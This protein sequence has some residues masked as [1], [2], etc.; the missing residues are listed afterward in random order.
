MLITSVFTAKDPVKTYPPKLK[1][2]F[3]E[4]ALGMLGEMESRKLEVVLVDNGNNDGRKHRSAE[5]TN[6]EWYSQLWHK[7]SYP[8]VNKNW[9]ENTGK[10]TRTRPSS[11]V[12]RPMI[13]KALKR[14]LDGKDWRLKTFDHSRALNDYE[15]RNIILENL[16]EGYDVEGQGTV[17]PRI[18]ICPNLNF[19]QIYEFEIEDGYSWAITPG[20]PAIKDL[21]K[22]KLRNLSCEINSGIYFL[23]DGLELVYIGVSNDINRRIKEHN[24]TRAQKEQP[25]NF[26]SFVRLFFE[27]DEA[28]ER[29]RDFIV[30]YLPKYNTTHN[31]APENQISFN[32]KFA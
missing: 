7:Y 4:E 27:Y 3:Q 9:K 11:Y 25:K 30:Y 26:N 5:N 2:L 31:D 23:F 21:P 20:L 6:P 29:E 12:Q 17:P 16:V 32:Y 10:N 13:I 22:T 28:L 14:I 8:T 15:L 24:H 1:E 19:K 18:E